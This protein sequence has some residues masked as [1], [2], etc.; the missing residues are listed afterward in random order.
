M[1]KIDKKPQFLEYAL[2]SEVKA[3]SSFRRCGFGE[4]AYESFNVCHYCG[5]SDWAVSENRKILSEKLHL[6]VDRFVFPKQ[7][8]GNEIL[9]IDE[10]FFCKTINERTFLLEGVDSLVT[11]LKNVCIGV[12]TADCVPILIYDPIHEVISAVHAGWRG[13]VNGVLVR[14][15]EYISERYSSVP[16]NLK[17]ILGPSISQESFE[18]G[19]EV[20]DA[21]EK[22]GFV[23]DQIARL[24]PK[25]NGERKWH[26]DLWGACC[27]QLENLGVP[28]DNIQVAGICTFNNSED[29]FSARRL[30]ANSGRIFNGIMMTKDDVLCKK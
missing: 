24:Y 21:F 3:F 15:V 12:F 6:S 4:G 2:S 30:G 5:D 10:D 11:S 7:K 23:M 28:L 18:V 27:I 16:L 17:V 20:Y 26:I 19:S 14:T 25:A 1:G 9:N 22:S 13:V 8:H 29:F